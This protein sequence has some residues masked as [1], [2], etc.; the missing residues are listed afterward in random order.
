M[1]TEV[2][3]E[4][5]VFRKQVQMAHAVVRMNTEGVAHAE[6]L[7]QPQPDGNCLNFVLGHL[8]NVYDQALPLVG[9]EPV[10]G[11]DALHR[12]RRGAPPLTEPA[13]ALPFDDLL[14]A[15]DTA[16]ERFGEGLGTLTAE[17]MTRPM[18]GPDSGGELTETVRS[19]VAT[20]VFHQ[21]YHAGQ[22]GVL[23]RI[24]GKPGAIP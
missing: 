2:Q 12:Y 23:R 19:L 4:I 18:P 11:A 17:A 16:S 5:E 21:A 7:V 22:T 15:W 8:L 1:S 24:V 3:G 20:I 13:D 9:Q 10:L 14:A 6:S